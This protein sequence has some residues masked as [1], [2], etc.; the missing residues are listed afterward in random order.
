MPL[1]VLRKHG[2]T[3]D[4]NVVSLNA[5]KLSYEERTLPAAALLLA[6]LFVAQARM[7]LRGEHSS[8]R[9]LGRAAI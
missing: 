3:S 5:G 4:R 8:L 2:I 1:P 7:R 9:D 6:L